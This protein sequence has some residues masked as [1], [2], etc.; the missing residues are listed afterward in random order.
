MKLYLGHQRAKDRTSLLIQIIKDNAR[1]Q[2]GYSKSI[3]EIDR[4]VK[5]IRIT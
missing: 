1:V 5:L 4:I 3:I 2:Y